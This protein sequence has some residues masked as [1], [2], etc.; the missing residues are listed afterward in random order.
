MLNNLKTLSKLKMCLLLV[1]ANRKGI[2]DIFGWQKSLNR[3]D[4]LKNY[5]N[6]K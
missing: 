6:G 5:K 1:K 4:D 3:H 2:R